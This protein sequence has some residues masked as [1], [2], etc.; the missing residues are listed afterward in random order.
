MNYI[1]YIIYFLL[2]IFDSVFNLVCSL[3][4]YYPAVDV[5]TVFLS[6]VEMIRVNKIIRSRESE[7]Q[8]LSG[9]AMEKVERIKHGKDSSEREKLG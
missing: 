6:R 7:K 5:A 1:K 9:D 2:S 4:R 8:D 3:F